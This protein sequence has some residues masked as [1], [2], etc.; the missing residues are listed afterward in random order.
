MALS[1]KEREL[2]YALSKYPKIGALTFKKI[3]D[4]YKFLENYFDGKYLQLSK[5]L[6][7]HIDSVYLSKVID[8][9]ELVGKKS[10]RVTV[11]GEDDYPAYLS[12]ISD[13]PPVLYS[14]GD[15]SILQEKKIISVVGTRNITEYG[16]RAVKKIIPE[17]VDMGF[18]VVSGMAFGVDRE[19]H[20]S[21][22]GSNGK[23]VAVLPTAPNLAIPKN[24]KDIYTKIVETGL[25]VSESMNEKEVPIGSFPKR[26]RII[27][28]LSLGT[29]VIE[30][31]QS[32]GSLITANL[33]FN[34]GRQVF[35]IPG[36]IDSKYSAGTNNLIKTLKAKLVDSSVDIAEELG[37]GNLSYKENSNFSNLNE[38]EVKIIDS[39][40][41][42]CSSIDDILNS[43]QIKMLE[44]TK[45]ITKLEI[46]GKVTRKIDGTISVA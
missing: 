40:M 35:A 21:T 38:D 16:K 27:A 31:S 7:I 11:F 41:S 22:I 4:E 34:E 9:I 25:V 43:T 28:G 19:V 10:V 14:V 20:I 46:S 3:I 12:K 39:I 2:R 32:S 1:S 8:E 29:L 15:L 37:F 33:A 18:V 23:T 44:L 45:L 6:K 24:N 5:S 26:N 30:A 42:G 36:M 13:P 17:L